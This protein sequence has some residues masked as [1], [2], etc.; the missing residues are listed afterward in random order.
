VNRLANG[1]VNRG[2]YVKS[3]ILSVII[4]WLLVTAGCGPREPFESWANR[5]LDSVRNQKQRTLQEYLARVEAKARALA[6]DS[7][8]V[9]FFSV[10]N[11]Y[12][13]LQK[14]IAP[15]EKARRAIATLKDHIVQHCLS[16]YSIFYDILCVNSAYRIFH[17]IRS[18]SNPVHPNL[19][20]YS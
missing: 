2:V 7:A 18:S 16:E 3:T 19:D 6:Q 11:E 12:Y 20:N 4:L 15:P 1:N 10:K 13:R 9:N 14:S 17:F 5:K 8:M